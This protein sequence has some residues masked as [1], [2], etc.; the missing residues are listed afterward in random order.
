MAPNAHFDGR[1]GG[2]MKTIRT[3]VLL[4]NDAHARMFEN[5]GRGAGLVE[6]EDM[7][8][9]ALA[10]KAMEV[11]DR[12]GRSSAA[13]GMA[14]HAFAE[15]QQVHDQKQAAFARA[16]LAEAEAQFDEGNFQRF[17]LVAAP[18]MLGV[19][20]DGLPKVLKEALVFDLAKDYLKL[21]PAEVVQHLA[22]HIAL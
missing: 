10:E 11:A 13:P 2:V 17:A 14:L 21:K 15:P 19:L 6:I 20:R 12:P 16:V 18:D 4:A 1:K 7:K 9:S 8:A 3:L 5:T 22:E